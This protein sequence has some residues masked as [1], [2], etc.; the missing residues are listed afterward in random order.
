MSEGWNKRPMTFI[1][2]VVLNEFN[3]NSKNKKEIKIAYI[4]MTQPE[5]IQDDFFDPDITEWNG[6]E[7]AVI[8]QPDGKNNYL[9]EK[10]E[11]GPSIF[12]QNNNKCEFEITTVLEEEVP[13]CNNKEYSKMTNSQQ[14]KYSNIMDVSKLYGNP[15]FFR[16][17]EFPKNSYLLLQLVGSELPFELNLGGCMGIMYVFLSLDESEGGIIIQN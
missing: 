6:G 3:E 5:S 2:Q 1:G 7:N 9:I 11:C 4:F 12:D 14:E 10:I 8:I 16:G 13:Y 17:E 15:Y